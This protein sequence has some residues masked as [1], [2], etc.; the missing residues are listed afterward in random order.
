VGLR[1]AFVL[2]VFLAVAAFILALTGKAEAHAVGLS[3]GTYVVDDTGVQVDLTFAR[4]DVVSLVPSIDPN[5]HGI[6]TEAGVLAARPELARV[7][8]G[9]VV[10]N[11]DE[12][13]CV[14]KLDSVSLTE[15][16]GLELRGHYDCPLPSGKGAHSVHVALPLLDKLGGGHRHLVHATGGVTVDQ[17]CFRGQSEFDV[18]LV[19]GAAAAAGAEAHPAP[20]WTQFLWM[21]VEHILTG[22]DHLVF[23][24]GLVLVG[25]RPKAILA[26]ITAFTLAHSITLA[27]ATL[28]VWAPSPRIVEPAI[29]LSI[30]YVGVENF[31]VK[32]AER[33]W[34]ITFPFG[35]IHGFGFAGALKEIGLPRAQIP[36]AL[37]LFNLGVETGQLAVLAVVLPLIY[38]LR[39]FEWFRD[40]A[41]KI[42]SGAVALA[43]LIWFIGRVRG[44]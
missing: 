11:A 10:V 19:P 14:P 1:T 33:R 18:P 24:F 17:V 8:L 6:I 20:T 9:G 13:P 7:I 43:G 42:L 31:F 28:G 37:V 21:G 15:Q 3:R 30:A 39:R 5:Q 35:L 23:L 12:A 4:A 36:E 27:M 25:G 29:A 16:D 38:W 32:T 40:R 44:G 34:R 41:V 26:V 2:F 22:Y